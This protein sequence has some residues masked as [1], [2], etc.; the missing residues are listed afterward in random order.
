MF[1]DKDEVERMPDYGDVIHKDVFMKKVTEFLEEKLIFTADYTYQ[2]VVKKDQAE[3]L[4][5]DLYLMY[6]DER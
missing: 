4:L 1:F 2:Q 3:K 6:R 5:F